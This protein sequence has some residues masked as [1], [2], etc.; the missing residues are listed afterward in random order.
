MSGRHP[1]NE[2]T[3]DV[4]PERRQRIDS[5]KSA[6]LAEFPE[7]EVAITNFSEVGEAEDAS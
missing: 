6:L 7:G 3:K 5:L 2:L 1:F 4:T